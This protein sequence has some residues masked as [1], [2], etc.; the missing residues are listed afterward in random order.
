M[1]FWPDYFI[2]MCVEPV[3]RITLLYLFL[4]L[5]YLSLMDKGNYVLLKLKKNEAFCL[6]HSAIVL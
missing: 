3:S 4:F 6:F 5:F 2:V 1:T